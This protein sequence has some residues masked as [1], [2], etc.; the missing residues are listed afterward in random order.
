MHK[1]ADNM[2]LYAKNMHVYA[3]NMQELCTKYANI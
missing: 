2:Q 3:N 1:C